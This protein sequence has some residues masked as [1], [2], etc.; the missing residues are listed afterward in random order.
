MRGE[1]PHDFAV[2]GLG[3]VREVTRLTR[4][5]LHHRAPELADGTEH[6]LVAGGLAEDHPVGA[7]VEV[8]PRQPGAFASRARERTRLTWDDLDAGTHWMILG[9]TPGHEIVLGAVGKFW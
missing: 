3:E 5:P 8:V 6:D 9:E 7:G 2:A 4:E 1:R